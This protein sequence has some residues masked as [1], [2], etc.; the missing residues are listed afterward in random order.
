MKS[1]A[2]AEA[3]RP[4]RRLAVEAT[5]K[6]KAAIADYE[7]ALAEAAARRNA[8]K[9]KME[10]AS[11]A[12]MADLREQHKAAGDPAEATEKRY[13][14]NDSTVE[15]LGELLNQN[16]RG[17]LHFRDELTGWLATLD[18]DGHQNDRAFFLEAWN[19]AGRYT[20]DRIAR[21][22]LHIDACCVSMLGGIQPGP[23][24]TYLRAALR[25]G[26]GDDG[27][28][29]RFQ[30]LVYP[31][32]PKTWRNVDRWPDSDARNR[33]FAVFERLDTLTPDAAGAKVEDDDL[34]FVRFDD[35][36]QE[37]FDGWRSDL[38]TR[39]RV[40]EEHPA[41]EAY[42]AKY[43]SLMPSLALLSHLADTSGG[44]VSVG[45][46]QRAA[47]WCDYLEAHARRVYATVTAAKAT[48][49]RLILAKLRAGK[50]RSPFAA[51]EAIRPQWAG[52]TD[53][54]VVDEA[55]TALVDAGWLRHGVTATRG[56]ARTEYT[57]HPAALV[58]VAA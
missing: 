11:D 14:V 47:A 55:L 48:A 51:W 40:D 39:L 6:H 16:P 57:A 38:M 53:R 56:K 30:L 12:A 7:A 2:L 45:A 15:K 58:K 10:K 44:A 21:G 18:R 24:A 41:I 22:T 33:A 9:R 52:L 37:L 34:P 36:A 50:L 28:I 29:Q 1:P 23:L 32:P 42:L 5:K 3:L 25:G 46:A 31:E 19:G 26:A 20:Y 13:I 4:V 43:P 27:L 35:A 49:A 8:I 54:E 17:L